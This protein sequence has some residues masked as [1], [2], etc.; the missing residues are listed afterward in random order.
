MIAASIVLYNPDLALLQRNI[1]AVSGQVDR[2]II[3]DNGS[4]NRQQIDQLFKESTYPLDIIRNQNNV[5]VAAALNQ[6]VLRCKE[7]GIDWLLTLDQDSVIPDGLV[8]TYKKYL[9]L[10]KA[11]QLTCAFID[12]NYSDYS[13]IKIVRFN[14]THDYGEYAE[15]DACITSGCL[16]NVQACIDIGLFDERLFIDNVDYDYS[17]RLRDNGYKI[18]KIKAARME[19]HLGAGEEKRFLFFRYIDY[20]YSKLRVYYQARN[21][22]YMLNAY[23]RYKGIFYKTLIHILFCAVLGGRWN[24][25]GAY[26]RGIRDGIKMEVRHYG[27]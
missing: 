15:V 24:V 27:K 3:I 25:I 18:Y 17:F 6:A 23:K 13:E 20:H 8:E 2:I 14:Y 9:D 21:N 19:H 1:E 7:S 26:T 4:K 22:V 12:P 11:G 16:M 10:E 5:G